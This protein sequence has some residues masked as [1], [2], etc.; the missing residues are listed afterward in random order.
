MRRFN[1]RCV[2]LNK[3]VVG[4]SYEKKVTALL[5]HEGLTVEFE[6]YLAGRVDYGDLMG[7]HVQDNS[8]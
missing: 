3:S 1:L 7:L 5:L 6:I 2:N 8:V 4:F